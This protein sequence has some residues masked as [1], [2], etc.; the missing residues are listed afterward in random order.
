MLMRRICILFLLILLG[1]AFERHASPQTTTSPRRPTRRKPV[2]TPTPTPTP[3]PTPTPTPSPE[4]E[5]PFSGDPTMAN[6]LPTLKPPLHDIVAAAVAMDNVRA[7]KL[8]EDPEK[9]VPLSG[10]PA[11]QLESVKQMLIYIGSYKLSLGAGC[12]ELLPADT[13][14]RDRYMKDSVV[15]ESDDQ[16]RWVAATDTT[17]QVTS[18]IAYE[19]FYVSAMMNKA[20]IASYLVQVMKMSGAYSKTDMARVVQWGLDSIGHVYESTPPAK[21]KEDIVAGRTKLIEEFAQTWQDSALPGTPEL[22]PLKP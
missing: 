3:M 12:W 17:G 16:F 15:D 6:I 11:D 4:P 7:K 1:A 10:V 18:S 14:G 8:G 20:K 2:A 19:T 13:P 9:A 21:R 22:H 5:G